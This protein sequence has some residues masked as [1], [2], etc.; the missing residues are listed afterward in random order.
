MNLLAKI[1]SY[2]FYKADDS[3][4]L[5]DLLAQAEEELGI[6]RAEFL[7]LKNSFEESPEMNLEKP[8]RYQKAKEEAAAFINQ[9]R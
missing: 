7:T 1:L 3:A 5:E 8:F 2:D 9:A 4:P 6:D